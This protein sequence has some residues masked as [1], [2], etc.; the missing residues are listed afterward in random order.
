[1]ADEKPP[2]PEQ[3]PVSM[4]LPPRPE[5]PAVS[6]PLPPSGPNDP[7]F[8]VIDLMRSAMR[9]SYA[10]ISRETLTGFELQATL[11]ALIELLVKNGAVDPAQLTELRDKAA[12][13]ISVAR[14]KNWA[15]PWLQAKDPE[16]AQKPDN[17]VDC[18]ARHPTCKAACCWL[19]RVVITEDEVRENKIG[20]DLAAPYALPRAAD[21]R[22]VNLDPETLGCLIWENRPHVCRRYHC[23][24]DT[25]VWTD[26]D[27]VIPTDV[28]KSRTRIMR[29]RHDDRTNP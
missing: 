8:R 24:H 27:K 21:G 11:E 19:Y 29:R 20:W 5:Q 9:T 13:R 7:M 28:V 12:D 16:D 25:N 15:G 17:I 10:M 22:C 18:N 2:R 14:D 1:M 3:P 26:F 23:R 6:M 4:P